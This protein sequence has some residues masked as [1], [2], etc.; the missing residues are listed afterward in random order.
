MRRSKTPSR[1]F[2]DS[3]TDDVTQVRFHPEVSKVMLSGATDGLVNYYDLAKVRGTM[4]TESSVGHI[5]FCGG[6]GGGDEKGA[7]YIYALTHIDTLHVWEAVEDFEDVA[8]VTDIREKYAQEGVDYLVGCVRCDWLKS[9]HVCFLAG[10]RSG[11]GRIMSLQG[12]ELKCEYIMNDGHRDVIRSATWFGGSE[13]AMVTGGED[14]M[15][16]G[17]SEKEVKKVESPVKDKRKSQS[18]LKSKVKHKVRG[19]TKPF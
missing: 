17:W 4:N 5:G 11:Q 8:S 16:C 3:H 9:D 14:G 18:E 13:A 12:N 2:E 6:G 10:S 7:K 1:R 15:L 19:S